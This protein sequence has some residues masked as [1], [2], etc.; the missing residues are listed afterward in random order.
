M[1]PGDPPWRSVTGGPRARP[2]PPSY[3]DFGH[4]HEQ[5]PARCP[6]RNGETGPACRRLQPQAG[7]CCSHNMGSCVGPILRCFLGPTWARACCA[8]GVTHVCASSASTRLSGGSFIRLCR[9]S[10]PHPFVL[11]GRLVS[12]AFQLLGCSTAGH[13]RRLPCHLFFFSSPRC[14]FYHVI[15]CNMR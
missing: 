11:H 9:G 5:G 4:T 13:L 15:V 8:C 1:H 7:M 3:A 2:G 12:R 6:A 10:S 14:C